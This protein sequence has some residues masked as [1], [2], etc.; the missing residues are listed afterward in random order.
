[1][2]EK[3]FKIIKILETNNSCILKSM[4]N[5]FKEYANGKGFSGR[6]KE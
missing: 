4:Q 3:R 2:E 6:E 1:L 5:T